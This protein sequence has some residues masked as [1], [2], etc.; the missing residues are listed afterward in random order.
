[1]LLFSAG[2]SHSESV[3]QQFFFLLFFFIEPFPF[4]KK[5]E[6]TLAMLFSAGNCHSESVPQQDEVQINIHI[7]LHLR[8]TLTAQ[9]ILNSK[10]NLQ[11][12]DF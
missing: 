7:T 11:R 4:M 12:K 10:T 9:I 1:M 6:K 5:G 3:L 8:H 2:N